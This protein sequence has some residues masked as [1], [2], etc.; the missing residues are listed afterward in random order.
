MLIKRIIYSS[1][2]IFCIWLALETRKHPGFFHPVIVE[3]GGDV[4]WAGAFLFL[5]R[6]IFIKTKAWKLAMICFVLG[7]IDE[8]SQLWQFEW[9][10]AARQ[11]YIGRLMLGV[12]FLWSDMVGYAIGTL[13]AFAIVLIIEGTGGRKRPE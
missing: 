6:C 4:I 9:I 8:Y 5:Q 13:L 7:V 11:T 3:Y 10:V 2:F 1:L 12:G